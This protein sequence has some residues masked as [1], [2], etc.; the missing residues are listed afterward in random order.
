MKITVLGTGAWGTALSILAAQNYN[1]VSLW[2]RNTDLAAQIALARENKIHLPGIA[3]PP[4]IEVTSDLSTALSGAGIV[5]VVV[6]SH[7]VRDVCKQLAVIPGAKDLRYISATKGIEGGTGARMTQ[8]I[9]QELGT[10][11]VGVLSGP[12]LARE[13]AQGMPAAAVVAAN[14]AVLSTDCQSAF[15]SDRYRVYTNEDVTGVELGGAFKNV[16][17]IAAGICDGLGLGNN[18]KA[19]LVTRGLFEMTRLAVAL[20]A[21]PET[22]SGLSGVGDLMVTCFSDLSRNRTLGQMLGRG[23]KLDDI[24]AAQNSV[25]EGVKTSRSVAGLSRH[26]GVETPIMTGVYA[27]LYEGLSVK[28]G[29]TQLMRRDLKPEHK[30]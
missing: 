22:L 23:L 18:S 8:I 1:Q 25:A 2:G 30:K 9:A 7:G 4:S 14:D 16:L 27:L 10:A 19:S 17:A 5:L 3:L 6:P 21:R 26:A 24:L 13:I 11:Q 15:S 20:G 28:E 12:N 29:I